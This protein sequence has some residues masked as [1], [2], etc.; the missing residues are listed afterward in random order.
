VSY[1][2]TS[3]MPVAQDKV[4]GALKSFRDGAVGKRLAKTDPTNTGWQRD[5]SASYNKIG[6]RGAELLPRRPRHH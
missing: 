1:N 5:L 3:E 2:K 6:R 4:D